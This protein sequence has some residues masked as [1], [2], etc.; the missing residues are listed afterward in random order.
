M[1]A[2]PALPSTANPSLEAADTGSLAAQFVN[3]VREAR[4]QK[5]ALD[6]RKSQD[7]AAANHQNL[8]DQFRARNEGWIP[9]PVPALHTDSSGYPTLKK[10]DADTA[11]PG[12]SDDGYSYDPSREQVFGG[13]LF[14]KPTDQEKDLHSGKAFQPTGWLKDRFDEVGHTGPV[15]PAESHSLL[16]AFNDH[17]GIQQKQAAANAP[18]V[19]IPETGIKAFDAN[20]KPVLLQR[21]S[22]S[23]TLSVKAL[24]DG[25]TLAEPKPPAQKEPHIARM[26]NRQTGDVTEVATDPQSGK[27][28]WRNTYKGAAGIGRDP[29]AEPPK[30]MTS[31]TARAITQTKNNAISAANT[32]RMKALSEAITP[33]DRAQANQEWKQS[34][35]A[36]Q[37][38]YEES[39][40][41]ATGKDLP[42][43]S[44]ADELSESGPATAPLNAAGASANRQARTS[45]PTGASGPGRGTPQVRTITA[46]Q[47][48]QYV[49]QK[50]QAGNPKFDEKAAR[51]EAKLRGI[52]VIDDPQAARA[53]AASPG[54]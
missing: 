33:E 44:W 29:N 25:V 46:D 5:A 34:L 48:R 52:Q 50:R 7:R 26:E 24:P 14:Y 49:T 4:A 30:R 13:A 45:G 53:A 16:Q 51:A 9:A 35:Q 28:L 38:N 3:A 32:K 20:G 1:A 22:K 11:Q 54:N 8:E 19:Q 39:I 43:N 42:H 18:E 17:L 6:Y 21:G 41:A 36:A 27:E 37:N 47:L 40:S 15:T 31:A 10:T 12:A 2:F 23:G